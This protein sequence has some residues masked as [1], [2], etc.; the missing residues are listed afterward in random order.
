ML[1]VN[2][3]QYYSVMVLV[4]VSYLYDMDYLPFKQPSIKFEQNYEIKFEIIFQQ[5]NAKERQT[6]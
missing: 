2:S 6:I 5:E 3:S 4:F 1:E